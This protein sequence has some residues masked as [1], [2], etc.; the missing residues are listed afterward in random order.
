MSPKK[1]FVVK[2]VATENTGSQ[3][4]STRVYDGCKK[5]RPR[6]RHGHV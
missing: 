4:I 5:S 3:L 1:R 2:I 6:T